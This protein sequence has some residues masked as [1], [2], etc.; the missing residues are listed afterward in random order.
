VRVLG[1]DVLT[2]SLALAH[3]L[4]QRAQ[5]RQLRATEAG[6]HIALRRAPI[7]QGAEEDRPTF[8]RQRHF[9][10]AQITVWEKRE[11]APLGEALDIARDGGGITMGLP[12]FLG[13]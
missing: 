10:F 4:E 6:N 8:F 11:Q 2:G 5:S 7:R 12:R 3:V 13:Q 9:A 1:A